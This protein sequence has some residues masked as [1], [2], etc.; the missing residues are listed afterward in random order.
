MLQAPASSALAYDPFICLPPDS[1]A[2]SPSWALSPNLRLP[3]P[4]PSDM[5]AGA[6]AQWQL[7]GAGG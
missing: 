7:S 2:R 1:A 6:G 3:F 5:C 4:C